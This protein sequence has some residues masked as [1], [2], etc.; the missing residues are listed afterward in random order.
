MQACLSMRILTHVPSVP[1]DHL[2]PFTDQLWLAMAA[3][4]ARVKGASRYHTES[5]LRC[6]RPGAQSMPWTRWPRS[7]H[8]ELY[9]GRMQ[10]VLRFRPSTVS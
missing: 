7:P 2:M 9:V 10:E 3:Y 5:D 6:Y 8:L 4:L 1:S